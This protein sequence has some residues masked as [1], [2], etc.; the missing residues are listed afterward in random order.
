MDLGLYTFGDLDAGPGAALVSPGQRL[1]EVVERAELAE[2]VGLD[3][4]GIGEH[5]RPDYA[6]SAPSVVVAAILA[7]TG[8]I[9]V[10][11]AVT[12]LSTEDPVRVFQE[13]ATM[14]Q[15]SDGR[16]ELLVGR[17]SFIESF[18]L[19]GASLE[20]Y[21]ALFEE[22]LDLLLRLDGGNPVTWSGRFRPGLTDA[23]V[24]PR[25]TDKPDAG[26][27]LRI[28]VATGGSPASSRRAGRLGLPVNYAVIGGEPRR[29][30]PLVELYR[31]AYAAAGH[32]SGGDTV[33]VSGQGF[34]AETDAEA[35]E[36]FYPYWLR[37]ATKIADERGFAM[38]NRISYEAQSQRH[39]AFF[40]GSPETVAEQIVTLHG[41]LGHDRQLFQMDVSGVPDGASMRAVELL[42]RVKELVDAEL[43]RPA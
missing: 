16:V 13:F 2:Q 42:G 1:R 12:V 11:S 33:T 35:R 9:S 10:G 3:H 4:V 6:V 20:D 39:G 22:K 40:I 5:H 31:E 25:P 21:D 32:P 43:A 36:T 30:A 34:V 23:V 29:F 15:L 18:S 28:A 41:Y 24:L 37:S 7:R 19:F 27:H 8:R 26:E 17:G 38:P 14:D